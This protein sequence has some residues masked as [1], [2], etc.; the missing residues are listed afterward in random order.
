MLEQATVDPQ[1]SLQASPTHAT[2]SVNYTTMSQI[3]SFLTG[4]DSLLGYR[5]VPR[6]APTS[7]Q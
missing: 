3:S 2:S 5:V 7:V 6:W 1:T 4:A